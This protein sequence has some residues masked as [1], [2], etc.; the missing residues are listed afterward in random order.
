MKTSEFSDSDLIRDFQN[1]CNESFETL[2]SRYETK[3]HNLATRLTRNAEDA[4]EVLQDVFVTIYRKIGSFEGKSQFSSWLYRV[5]VN[6]AFMKLRK[7]KQ[8]QAMALEDFSPQMYANAIY[9]QSH[10]MLR[11]DSRA[12]GNEVRKAL[13][14]AITKLPEDYRAVFI[15]RDIDGLSNEEAS[16]VLNLSVPAIKSRLHRSRII[17]RKRLKK[18]F[19]DYAHAQITPS[20][21]VRSIRQAA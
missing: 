18:V 19:E 6:T 1:G 7:R 21:W 5:T 15:L 10:C 2:L 11:C 16:K 14:R 13:E 8:D 3:V 4:E 12:E 9:Q 17:L 20:F